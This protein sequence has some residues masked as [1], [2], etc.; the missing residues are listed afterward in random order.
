MRVVDNILLLSTS[1]EI[2][3]GVTQTAV[4]SDEGVFFEVRC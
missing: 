4:N 1:A 2:S 3:N